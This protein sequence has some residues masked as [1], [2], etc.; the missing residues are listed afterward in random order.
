[1]IPSGGLLTSLNV[2]NVLSDEK[3]Q[4]VIALGRLGWPLRRIQKETGVRRETAGTYLKAVGVPVRPPGGWGRRS[5]AK[6]ANEVAPDPVGGPAKPAIEAPPDSGT[7]P[8]PAS[9]PRASRCEPFL[10]FIELSLSKGRNAKGIWQNLV[11]DHG[12]TGGYSGVKRFV[13]KLRGGSNTEA[14]A[15]ITTPPGE[16]GQVDYG[17]GP[18]VRDPHS[19][20]YRRTR[21][22]VLTL[23]YSRKAVRLL[24]WNSS[25]H[26]WAELHERAF[27]RLGGTPRLLVLDNLGEGVLRPDIYDPIT[28]PLYADLLAHYGAAAL[29]CRVRDPDR[30]GKVERAVGHAKQTPLKGL[31]FESMEEAQT[32]LD[33]WEERWAD[34]RIHGTTKRQVAVMFAEEKPALLPL[35]LEPFRFYQ[36]GERTVNLDGCVEVD[37]AYYSAPP[38]WIGRR[39]KVQWDQHVVR[40][41]DPRTGQLLREHLHQQR[42]RHRIPDEDRPAHALPSTAHLLARCQAAG[43]Q[44]GALCRRMYDDTGVVAIRR[45]QGVLALARKHGAAL[46]DDGCAAALESGVIHDGYRFLRRWLERRPQLTLCQVDPIIRQL[47]LYRDLIAERTQ[48]N[49]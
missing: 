46:A 19:G 7:L 47:T 28:N 34:T 33:R 32:Y 42:G 25:T 43:P 1:M 21:M 41:L 24:T 18:M 22:F 27:R 9:T 4:Q 37:A 3:R 29:P 10:E 5:P 16:E 44:I 26:V 45:I 48:E 8:V 6:P 2:S 12:F 14:R 30:K 15:V 31:R 17:S 40:V 35:P 36:F 13:R 23:G 11:D 20:R 39:V 49:L 38:G